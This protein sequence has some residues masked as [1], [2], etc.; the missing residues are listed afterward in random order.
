M[1]LKYVDMADKHSL[2]GCV[3]PFLNKTNRLTC[4]CKQ[5]SELLHKLRPETTL[6]IIS[7][8]Y[9][10]TIDTLSN[11]QTVRLWLEKAL[12][13]YA[14]V[15]RHHS[16]GVSIKPEKMTAWGIAPE[17]QFLLWDWVWRWSQTENPF[18]VM[19]SR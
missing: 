13:Q 2:L 10:S 4:D 5:L 16:V 17:N 12:G 7:S 1:K 6:F 15:L 18:N 19:A 3:T 9:F 8:K 14:Q 11:A